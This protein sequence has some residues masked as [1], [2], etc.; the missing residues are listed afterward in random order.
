[1]RYMDVKESL[2]RIEKDKVLRQSPFDACQ[3]ILGGEKTNINERYNSFFI[4]YSLVPLLIQENYID[5]AKNGIFKHPSFDDAAKLEALSAAA[6]AVSDMELA[7]SS[8]MGENQH[9]ELL[10]VQAGMSVRVGS[11]VH[12]FQPVPSFP[13]WLGKNSTKTKKK[14]LTQEIVMHTSLA[15]GQ[16]FSPIRLDYIP[17]L[18]EI[19]LHVLLT[20]EDG[21]DKAIEIFDAVG[22]SQD[23]FSDSLRELQFSVEDKKLQAALTDRYEKMDT[24]LKTALTKAYN[25]GTH[26]SQALV[27]MQ[28]FKKKRGGGSA[29]DAE[30][31]GTTEDMEAVKVSRHLSLYALD[32][33]D[34]NLLFIGGRGRGRGD[35]RPLRLHEES[36]KGSFCCSKRNQAERKHLQGTQTRSEEEMSSLRT[37]SL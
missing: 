28:G 32:W 3:M 37:F 16:G 23:D 11:L 15:I 31:E 22:I 29:E 13:S 33:I 19:L 20:H 4:D 25:S 35:R 6:M 10:P 17:Y 34:N 2:T 18:R 7:G 5:S 30:G 14:R 1:M 21:V 27:A 24:R 36:Q 12:G 9:W 8:I 26:R